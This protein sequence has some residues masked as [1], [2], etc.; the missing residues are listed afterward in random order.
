[1]KRNGLIEARRRQPGAFEVKRGD[2][3]QAERPNHV[4]EAD[5]Q[6]RFYMQDKDRC[7]PLTVTDLHSRYL[8]K[9][10]SVCPVSVP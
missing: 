4:W 10:Q 7:D 1:L 6:C 2:L 8:I 5:Y 9:K 3:T